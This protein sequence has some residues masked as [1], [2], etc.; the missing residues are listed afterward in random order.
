MIM[1]DINN[2][3]NKKWY[4]KSWENFLKNNTKNIFLIFF[5]KHVHL[6]W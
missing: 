5:Y 3:Y 4:D 2:I 1:L 6:E